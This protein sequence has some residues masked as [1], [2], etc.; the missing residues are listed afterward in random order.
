[1]TPHEHALRRIAMDVAW[2]DTG[3]PAEALT[4][5]E[6]AAII[7]AALRS[8]AGRIRDGEPVEVPHLGVF[9]R[10][11]SRHGSGMT[12]VYRAEPALLEPPTDPTPPTDRPDGL[13][14]PA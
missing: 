14:T 12:L 4:L 6:L 10:S 11:R 7:D 9:A 2:G 1:M 3:D 8:V 5:A 13:E